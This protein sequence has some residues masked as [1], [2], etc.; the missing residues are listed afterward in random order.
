[1]KI[2]IDLGTANV[3]VYV[4]GKGIAITEPSVVAVSD[5]NRIVVDCNEHGEGHTRV[6]VAVSSVVPARHLNRGPTGR[7]ARQSPT[8]SRPRRGV[9]EPLPALNLGDPQPDQIADDVVGRW[10]RRREAKGSLGQL[11]AS[12]PIAH[13]LDRGRADGKMLR[14]PFAARKPSS[15]RFACFSDAMP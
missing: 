12:E 9:A 2:G 3:L 14:C 5:D 7:P 6:N 8:R 10:L 1:M 15:G 11:E 13:R 4:K